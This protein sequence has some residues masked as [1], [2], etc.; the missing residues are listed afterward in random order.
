VGRSRAWGRPP[1]A[2]VAPARPHP[3]AR[4]SDN[5]PA[6]ASPVPTTVRFFCG[7]KFGVGCVLPLIL[8]LPSLPLGS[9]TTVFARCASREPFIVSLHLAVSRPSIGVG[10]R[11]RP[12][13]CNLCGVVVIPVE[14]A[15]RCG[16]WQASQ[17]LRGGVVCAEFSVLCVGVVNCVGCVHMVCV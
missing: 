4:A 1:R 5:P 11:T 3:H 8:W 6:P 12:A 16:R 2:R 15:V 14:S 17:C 7:Y 13:Y 9:R 10:S